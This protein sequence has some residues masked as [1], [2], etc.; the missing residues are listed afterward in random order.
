MPIAS[1][2][3]ETEMFQFAGIILLIM[4]LSCGLMI[5]CSSVSK[6]VDKEL[7]Q[8]EA[9]EDAK[10]ITEED[11]RPLPE[12]MQRYLKY[13]QVIGKKEINCVRLKQK[14]YIRMNEKQKWMP[15][16]AEQYFS[17]DEPSFIWYAKVK[18]FP[19]ISIKARDKY[20]SGHGNMFIKLL[21]IKT[22]ADAKGPEIDQSS[23]ERYL[24]EMPWFP[25]AFLRDYVKYEEIDSNSVK[26]TVEDS[27]LK[28]FG[29]FYIDDIGRIT[30]AVVDG[31][32]MTVGDEYIKEKWT[33]PYTE[34]RE[35]SGFRI[36]TKGE[37]TWNLKTGDF[38]YVKL[39]LTDVEYDNPNRY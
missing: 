8:F 36:P 14:G 18:M 39:E 23:L 1:S 6:M 29:I 28:V 27:G 5:G 16:E 38:T 3:K 21:G 26:I 4:L 12:A 35:M 34:Y 24:N 20:F 10:T 11:I 2:T 22:I 33:T 15:F 7:K 13:A 31:R 19:L 9:R 17:A 32:Y 37:A 25:T 30:H